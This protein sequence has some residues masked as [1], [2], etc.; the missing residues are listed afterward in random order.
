MD[1]ITVAEEHLEIK[2]DEEYYAYGLA[3]IED[4]AIFGDIDGLKP[5]T[6]RALWAAHE[7]GLRHNG[8]RDKSAKVV[9][10]TMGD[11]HPHGDAAIYGAVVT[12]A[13]TSQKLFDG[14]GNWG[15]MTDPPAAMRYT[16]LRLTKYADMVFF[17]RFYLA[18]R[19]EVENYDGSRKEPLI[20]PSLLPNALL[21]GNFGIAPGVNTRTPTITLASLVPVLISTFKRG[22]CDAA[23]CID[24][25]LTTEYGARLRKTR[26]LQ[27]ELREFYKTGK[28]RFIFDSV[29]K[30]VAKDTIRIDRFAPFSNIES[31]LAKVEKV[32][33]VIATRD[34][35]DKNDP[36]GN[37]YTVIFSK[38]T[39]GGR[40]KVAIK[41]VME[42]FSSALSYSMQ[43]SERFL[44]PKRPEGGKKLHP[45][46]VP[47]LINLWCKYRTDLEKRACTYWTAK[48]KEEIAYLNLMR[49]AVKNR[50]FIIQAL[51]KNLNDEGLA[52]YIAK[53]LKITVDQAN[54]ILDLKVRQLKALEDKVLIDKIKALKEEIAGY[55]E[56][57]KHPAKYIVKHLDG[58]L[59]ELKPVEKAGKAGKRRKKR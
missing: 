37:A 35:S 10:K 26:T 45:T 53:G 59:D 13:N 17:D 33:G 49:L 4:R 36:Y 20:L 2:A 43:V 44:D 27:S 47:D 18:V 23:M 25:E 52:A 11:Y 3:V 46:T 7:M 39:T 31:V 15:T 48:R 6:R 21:N 50:R 16:N 14:E 41:R 12:A 30:L 29:P 5:V 1:K 19:D 34:D 40:L 24:L 55:A 38:T 42:C 58:L 56:R 57:I 54:A 8:T 9:G 51:D 28:G 22:K 32:N